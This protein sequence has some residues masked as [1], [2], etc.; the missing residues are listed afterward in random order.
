MANQFSNRPPFCDFLE[1]YL[2]HYRPKWENSQLLDRRVGIGRF[3]EWLK[4]CG[5]PLAALDWQKLLEFHRF[6]SAQGGSANACIKATQAAKH[7]LRWGI[8]QGEL[9]QKLD[10]I[11]AFQH[12]RHKWNATLPALSQEFLDELEP[13]RPGSF[14][15]HRHTHRIFHTFLAEKRLTYRRLRVEHMVLF[16]KYVAKKEFAVHTRVTM[17]W[18]VRTYLRRLH[19]LRKISRHPDDIFPRHIIPKDKEHLPRPVDSEVDRRLQE[20]LEKTEDIYYKAI[21]LLRRTGLRITELRKLEFDCVQTDQNGRTSLIVPVIKLGVERR[22]PLDSTTVELIRKIQS[23]S[24]GNYRKKSPPKVLVI[25]PQG[26]SPRYERYSAVMG[27]LCAR[28]G[29]KKWINLHALRHT[30]ATALLDAGLPITSLKEILGHKV[31]NTSLLYAKVSQQK[32]HAEYSQ[33]LLHMNGQ[34]IPKI[35]E[36]KAGGAAA[37]FSHLGASIA[38]SLDGCADPVKE[39]RLRVLRNRL[40]KLKMELLRDL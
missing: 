30:Y 38:K 24:L 17:C 10:E 39:K 1:R 32:I 19:Q 18:H 25:G 7:A 3:D 13:T 27:E 8:E 22:V 11:Y 2:A 12:P 14:V 21:L 20:L 34:Q 33:A 16:V 4:V 29:V 35:M 31:I 36:T 9:P 5:H 28:L 23:M 15:A 6:L 37:S 26:T 40:A